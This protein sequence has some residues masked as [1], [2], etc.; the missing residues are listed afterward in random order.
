MRRTI[1]RVEAEQGLPLEIELNGSLLT[2]RVERAAFFGAAGLLGL[3]LVLL[4]VYVLLPLL[5]IAIGVMFA[6]FGVLVV[7]LALIFAVALVGGVLGT[8]F[9]RRRDSNDEHR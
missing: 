8:A 5:G 4:T 6:V 7:V 3:G 9:H 1:I 2:G